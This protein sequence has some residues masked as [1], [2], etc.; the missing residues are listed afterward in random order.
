MHALSLAAGVLPDFPPE[1]VVDA[2]GHAGFG[3]V[4]L[5]VRPEQ[6]SAETTRRVRGRLGAWQLALLDVEVVWIPEGGELNDG[7]RRIV[8]VGAELG[9]R[10]VLVVSSEPDTGRAAAALRRLCD[11][12][13]PAGMRVALEFLMLTPIRTLDQP[14]A[15]IRACA[16]PAAALLVDALHLQRA[17][18]RPEALRAVDPDLLHYVQFCD[19]RS[20]CSTSPEAYLEDAVDQRSAPGEGELPLA[21]LLDVL[22]AD[23]PLSLEVRSRRYRGRF[24]DP[25]ERAAAIRERTLRFLDSVGAARDR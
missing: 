20:A 21:A 7:H 2:A 5:T 12:A 11:W 4:G 14:L 15:V 3:M 18:H 1:A 6:W 9:A 13:E 16:H 22:P 17:G 23:C 19:G 8:D 25:A 24:P 10:N